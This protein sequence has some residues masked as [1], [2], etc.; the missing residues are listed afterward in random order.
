MNVQ[1]SLLTDLLFILGRI[2]TKFGESKLNALS[3]IGIHNL[4]TLLFVLASTFSNQQIVSYYVLSKSTRTINSLFAIFLSKDQRLQSTLLQIRLERLPV[5]RQVIL[6]KGHVALILLQEKRDINVQSYL[7]KILDQV[8]KLSSDENKL[9][10]LRVLIE[11]LENICTKDNLFSVGTY[12]IIG[13][14]LLSL[15]CSHINK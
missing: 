6:I 2:F 14:Y 7:G 4:Q 13:E 8:N 9:P 12:M 5:S 10:V 11:I 15:S 3:E 1:N